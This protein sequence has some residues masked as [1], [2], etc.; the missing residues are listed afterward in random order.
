[1]KYIIAFNIT[2][3]NSI[4]SYSLSKCGMLKKKFF[5]V[6]KKKIMFKNTVEDSP[7]TL[8]VNINYKINKPNEVKL[9]ESSS[10]FTE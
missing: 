7:G 1:M 5:F 2:G 6:I 10:F 8:G 3:N 9:D 4:I